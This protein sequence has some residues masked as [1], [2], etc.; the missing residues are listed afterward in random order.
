[1]DSNSV[2]YDVVNEM[3]EHGQTDIPD[4]PETELQIFSHSA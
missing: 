1:M 2:I 3:S 4:T